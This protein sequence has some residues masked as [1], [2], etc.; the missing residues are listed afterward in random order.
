MAM[1]D[2]GLATNIGNSWGVPLHLG[3]A[4]ETI[5]G[6]VT[7]QHPGLASRDFSS[8]YLFLKEA[9]ERMKKAQAGGLP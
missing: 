1:K 5:Y 6:E 3:E 2:L 7:K 4:A 8:V 9:A